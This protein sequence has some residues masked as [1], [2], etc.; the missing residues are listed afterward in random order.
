MKKSVMILVLATIWLISNGQTGPVFQYTNPSKE[1]LKSLALEESARGYAYRSYLADVVGKALSDTL[2]I[3]SENI[4]WIFNHLFL[5][6]VYFEEE[7]YKNSGY[8]PKTQKMDPSRGHEKTMFVWVLRVGSY[9]IPLIKGD[10]GNILIAK[11]IRIKKQSS[12]QRRDIDISL[13]PSKQDDLFKEKE[14]PFSPPKDLGSASREFKSSEPSNL[15]EV[16]RN[17]KVV[18]WLKVATF[19][20]IGVGVVGTA[21]LLYAIL[22]KNGDNKVPSVPFVPT[23]PTGP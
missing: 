20:G 15:V 11:V 3:S 12:P 1:E 14:I 18:N 8:D 2:D 21:A 23:D 19:G 6:E 9:A 4:D 5:E 13:S 16:P 22:N 7:E 17:K 10:C